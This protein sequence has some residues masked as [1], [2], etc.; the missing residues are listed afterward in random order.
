[1]SDYPKDDAIATLV[2]MVDGLNERIKTLEAERARLID[3][4]AVV[5]MDRDTNAAL[6][7]AK[8]MAP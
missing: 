7:T 5:Q 8:R 4:L 2:A 6:F 1:M 3:T